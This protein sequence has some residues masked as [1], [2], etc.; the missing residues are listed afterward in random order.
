[1]CV[2]GTRVGAGAGA[3]TSEFVADR[4]SHSQGCVGVLKVDGPESFA[5]R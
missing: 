4:P 2:T 5:E 1:M 3:D